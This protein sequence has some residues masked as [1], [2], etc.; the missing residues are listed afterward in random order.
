MF[1]EL[2][3]GLLFSSK[4][5]LTALPNNGNDKNSKPIVW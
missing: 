4:I 3:G 5:F 1:Q 2:A